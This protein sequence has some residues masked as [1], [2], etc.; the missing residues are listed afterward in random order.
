MP[1]PTPI[2][3]FSCTV[4]RLEAGD[5]F[6]H[7]GISVGIDRAAGNDERAIT[8]AT[9]HADGTWLQATLSENQLERLARLLGYALDGTLDAPIAGIGVV[10]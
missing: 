10:R 8:L 6:A 4:A 9:R 5:Q 7:A 2:R 3:G 1:D